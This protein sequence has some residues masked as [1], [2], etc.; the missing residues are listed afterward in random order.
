[1]CTFVHLACLICCT[2]QKSKSLSLRDRAIFTYAGGE[3]RRWSHFPIVTG[4]QLTK[5]MTVTLMQ[6][7][8]VKMNPTSKYV[9]RRKNDIT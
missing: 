8:P 5:V 6:N 9:G 4:K 2:T 1:M 7:W 3:Q